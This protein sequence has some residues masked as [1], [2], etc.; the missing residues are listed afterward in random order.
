MSA[1]VYSIPDQTEGRRKVFLKWKSIDLSY[2]LSLTCW[3][4][5]SY[6][7]KAHHPIPPPDNREHP[8]SE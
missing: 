1:Q 6:Y 8:I 4:I 7:K 3:S 2:E 5:V